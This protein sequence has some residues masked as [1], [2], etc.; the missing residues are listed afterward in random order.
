MQNHF[1]VT[2]DE[3]ENTSFEMIPNQENLPIQDSSTVLTLT[4]SFFNTCLVQ[5]LLFLIHHTGFYL[6]HKSM[7]K[8]MSKPHFKA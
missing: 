1:F 3:N 7:S 5:N 4:C 2:Q 8:Q 6:E